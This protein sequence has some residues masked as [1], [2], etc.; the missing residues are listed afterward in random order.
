MDLAAMRLEALKLAVRPNL[1][2]V[3]IIKTAE[4]YFAFIGLD[5]GETVATVDYPDEGEKRKA[6]RGIAARLKSAQEKAV[7]A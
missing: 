2:T 3:D 4:V 5:I 6:P 1:D 7:P